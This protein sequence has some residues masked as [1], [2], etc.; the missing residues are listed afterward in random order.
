LGAKGFALKRKNESGF[1]HGPPVINATALEETERLAMLITLSYEPMLAWRLDGPIEF[2]NAGAE[3]LYGFKQTE[4]VGQSSHTLLQTRHPIDLADLRSQLRDRRHWMGE[5]RHIRKDGSEVI[6]ESRMQLF[7]EEVVLEANRDITERRETEIALRETERWSRF[8]AA[9][10]ESSDDIIV[11]K[12]LDGIITSWNKG[13]E[14]VL[15]YSASEAVGQPITLVIPRDRQN[16]EREILTRIRRGERID[17]FETVRQRKDGSLINVSLT[18]FR[19]SRIPTAKSLVRRRS[20]EILPTAKERSGADR[21]IG[22]GSRA[23]KQELACERTCGGQSVSVKLPRRTQ[24]DHRRAYRG[25]CECL[26][27]ICRE[28]L[29]RCGTVGDR[30]TG[31]IPI[32]RDAPRASGHRRA[33]DPPRARRCSGNCSYVARARDQRGEIRRFVPVRRSNPLAMVGLGG[34]STTSTL[35]GDRRP[36]RGGAYATGCRQPDH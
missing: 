17:H 23:P 19:R 28:P 9:I 36:D 18:P 13:A 11:S 32:F 24:T 3:R 25:A 20:R 12:S 6:V 7:S 34:R 10:V 5:L 33:A 8:L 35:D 15:G 14:R 27:V 29:D 4:A 16:E 26:L 31:T 2:W 30:E 21:N 1:E 22:K